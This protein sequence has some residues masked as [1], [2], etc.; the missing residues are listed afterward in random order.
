MFGDIWLCW[1]KA[2]GHPLGI[3]I[4]TTEMDYLGNGKFKCP[5]CK[6]ICDESKH[7]YNLRIKFTK[8]KD[9]SEDYI[10]AKIIPPFDKR[11]IKKMHAD[12]PKDNRTIKDCIEDDFRDELEFS[13]GIFTGHKEGV[14]DCDILWLW[15]PCGGYDYDEWDLDLEL[16]QEKEVV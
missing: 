11:I 1:C 12:N 3:Q 6:T 13:E 8:C 9:E 14:F 10:M 16:I 2:T 7:I 5:K 15:Y 4:S